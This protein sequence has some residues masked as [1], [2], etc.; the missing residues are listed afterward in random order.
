MNDLTP[1]RTHSEPD[2]YL[3]PFDPVRA[4]ASAT[5]RAADCHRCGRDAIPDLVHLVDGDGAPL[6]PDC[7]RLVGVGLR[8]GLL[9]LN[10]LADALR[11]PHVH[12]VASLVW[13]WHAALAIAR[14]EEEHLLRSAAQLL[15]AHL[16]H[17]AHAEATKEITS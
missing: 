8:R 2:D 7:T 11:Q 4:A 1:I 16:G 12:P 6:C 3:G 5:A 9:A 14:P 13:D 17:N 15:A 10:Q